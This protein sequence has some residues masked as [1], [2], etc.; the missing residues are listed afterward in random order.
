MASV[1]L[2]TPTGEQKGMIELPDWAFGARIHR[3]AMWEAV[4]SYLSNQ[5][6]GTVMTKNRK[7]VR[8][9]GKK[10]W[11]QKKTGR[12]R[13]GTIRSPLWVGGGR[14][15]GPKPRS[16]RTEL[17]KQIRRLA[18]R[19]ALTLKAKDDQVAVVTEIP[20]KEAR[21]KEVYGVL[22][23]IGL[24]EV[25]TLLVLPEH[26]ERM[27]RAARN[28]PKVATTVYTDLHTYQV[29]RSDRILLLETT[30]QRMRDAEV[31]Q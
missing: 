3:H 4:R 16:Y 11:A 8:G 2:Y 7:L 29:L 30:I 15:H 12:A 22:R 13:A 31:K 14:A 6:L 27:L 18:V 23:N 10:P 20:I 26:D 25:K 5:R 19:S 28:L 17:P 9:G 21:T 1:T 24:T